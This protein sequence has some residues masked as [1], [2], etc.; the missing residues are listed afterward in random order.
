MPKSR[1]ALTAIVKRDRNAERQDASQPEVKKPLNDA[2][3]DGGI[4]KPTY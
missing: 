2:H 1:P 4:I 3:L